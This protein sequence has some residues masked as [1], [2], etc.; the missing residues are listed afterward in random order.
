VRTPAWERLMSRIGDAAMMV[1]LTRCVVAVEADGG[2][3]VQVTGP[4]L[5]ELVRAAVRGKGT[6]GWARYGVLFC[7]IF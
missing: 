6:S 4:A 3:L 5:H 7:I 2:C 1:L